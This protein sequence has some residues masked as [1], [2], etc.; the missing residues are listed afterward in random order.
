MS[1]TPSLRL[2]GA[3]VR[4]GGRTLWTGL[5]LDV[6]PGEFV[7]VL[8]PERLGQDDAALGAARAAPAGGRDVRGRRARAAARE[9]RPSGYV[10]QHT[11]VD[12]LTPLRGRD[13]VGLGL[14]GHRFGPALRGRAERARKVRE[15][16]LQVDALDLADA[17]VGALSGGEQQRLRIAQALVGDPGLLLADEPLHSLDLGPPA[18]PS[19]TCSSGAA[20]STAPRWCS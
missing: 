16:L 10:P 11:N 9:R 17:P 6:A 18:R 5:D 3:E 4:R 12:P 13:L 2:S 20:V 8:G 1:S 15:A 19:S 14:D 7:T